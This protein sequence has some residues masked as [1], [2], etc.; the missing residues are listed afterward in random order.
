MQNYWE[1]R[2][3]QMTNAEFKMVLSDLIEECDLDV[4]DLVEANYGN[5][6]ASTTLLL[7]KPMMVAA[8]LLALMLVAGEGTIRHSFQRGEA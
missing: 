8:L 4:S 7:V 2:D 5:K 1:K 3:E 6:V